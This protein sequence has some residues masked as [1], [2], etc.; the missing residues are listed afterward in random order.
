M[1]QGFVNLQH[2]KMF[3][4]DEGD[5]M[6]D[7]GFIVDIKKIIAKLPVKKQTMLFSATMPQDIKKL[8]STILI[9]PAYIDITPESPTVDLINQSMY[10]VEKANKRPLLLHLLKD[11]AI[12]SALVFTRT[13]HGAD[14]VVV[15]LKRAGVNAEAIHGNKS[16]G[17]RQRALDNFKAKR[18]RVLV[19]TD[20]ASRGIDIEDLSHVINFEMSNEA[21]TY[22]HRIGR[23]GRAGAGGTALSFCDQEERSYLKDIHRLINKSIPVI[24]D[25]PFPMKSPVVLSVNQAGESRNTSGARRRPSSFSK[26]RNN[27]F[28]RKPA[29]RD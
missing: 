7:M 17:A 10:F 21:E 11:K 24:E 25:H 27:R 26:N 23:T 6:L 2:I 14:K 16:Q 15:D 19:A 8:S 29:R 3:V 1:N 18:T 5:R 4:L 28:A 13:K 12:V 22:V 9:N 20:I